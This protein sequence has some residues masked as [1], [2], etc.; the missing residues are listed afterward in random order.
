M[1]RLVKDA[2]ALRRQEAALRAPGGRL[3]HVDEKN[4]VVA[5]V[6][7]GFE[8]DRVL[9]VVNASNQQSA[10]GDYRVTMANEGGSWTE[11]FNSQADVYGGNKAT[12]NGGATLPVNN[13]YLTISLPPWSVLMFRS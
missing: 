10:H 4:H 2:N 1:Q 8:G 13:G 9:V 11:C 3:V 6:R 12:G 7:Y 5:F